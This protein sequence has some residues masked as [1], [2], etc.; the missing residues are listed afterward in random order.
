LDEESKNAIVILSS[1]LRIAEKLDRSHCALVK[2]VEFT[3]EK[4]GNVTLSFSSE[5]DCSLEK[6][7]ILQNRRAF[8]EAF[9]RQL[10]VSCILE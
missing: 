10:E 6:W 5:S 7:S 1:F 9:E 8:F 3:E 4:H 2:T